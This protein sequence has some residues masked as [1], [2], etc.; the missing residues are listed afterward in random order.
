MASGETNRSIEERYMPSPQAPDAGPVYLTIEDLAARYKVGIGTVR[1]WR[2]RG[3][4]PVV[5]KIGGFVRFALTD[6]L[7]WE[8]SRREARA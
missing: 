5:T 2:Y 6:V 4:G 1:E 3:T 7:A 8:R